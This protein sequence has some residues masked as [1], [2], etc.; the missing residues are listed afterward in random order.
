[1]TYIKT[2]RLRDGRPYEGNQ[3]FA[4]NGIVRSCGKCG[5]HFP[6][7]QMKLKKP[8]GVCCPSCRGVKPG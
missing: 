2:S 4:G 5:K 6:P 3:Q 8:W 7:G 1:M